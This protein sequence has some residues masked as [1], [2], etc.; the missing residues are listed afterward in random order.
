MNPLSF[1]SFDEEQ[2]NG[3]Y[4]LLCRAFELSKPELTSF[5]ESLQAGFHYDDWPP[6]IFADRRFFSSHSESFQSEYDNAETIA[7]DLPSLLSRGGQKT[8]VIIAQDPLNSNPAEGVWIG[9]PYGLHV[10]KMREE[11]HTKR[12]MQLIE[13]LLH[14]GY[15]TYLTDFYKIYVRDAKLPKVDKYLFADI[16]KQEIELI[17]PTAII[18]WGKIA[19]DAV[20]SLKLQIPQHAYPHPSGSAR[21]KWAEH[22]GKPATD[23]NILHYWENTVLQRLEP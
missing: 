16:L 9:T 1:C 7:C 5:Y 3:I 13:I 12:Y 4:H 19:S 23:D 2:F 17:K 10:K 14:H 21:W 22:M 8:V 18:T 11:K 15:Q 20:A 6:A